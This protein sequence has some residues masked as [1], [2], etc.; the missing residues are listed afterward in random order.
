MAFVFALGVAKFL[1]WCFFHQV[2]GCLAAVFFTT[3]CMR[4]LWRRV[5]TKGA[6]E[7]CPRRAA[8]GR[9]ALR[10][11]FLP[12]RAAKGREALR[13]W[14]L[15]RRGTKRHEALRRCLFTTKR[16]EEARS[17]AAVAF[18]TKRHEW[19]RSLAAVVFTTK[20]HEALRRCLFTTKRHEEARSLAAVFFYHEVARMSTKPCGGGFYHEEARSLADEW[21]TT[22]EYED[23]RS[24]AAEHMVKGPRV[25]VWCL[26]FRQLVNQG[27]RL[28][29][30]HARVY[31]AIAHLAVIRHFS[32]RAGGGR[33]VTANSVG[34]RN[35]WSFA[36]N[37]GCFL[38]A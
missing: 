11:W 3:K 37:P 9:E 33:G 36:T 20:R 21:L 8:K 13:R 22:K 28:L 10:R 26:P 25:T 15:P 35:R 6:W 4:A 23:A 24:L 12:R 31:T 29:A 1:R 38:R 14:F 2:H 34:Y 16:H 17:L 30:S 19:A 32:R 18:T 27:V 7:F 5:S